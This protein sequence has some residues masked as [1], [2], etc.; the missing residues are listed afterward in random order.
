[1][2]VWFVS[3]LWSS[4]PYSTRSVL[5]FSVTLFSKWGFNIC[6][7]LW[8]DTTYLYSPFQ[9]NANYIVQNAG[10]AY[11]I[12]SWR[13]WYDQ[14]NV[15]S[16]RSNSH[17]WYALSHVALISPP[18]PTFA[19][20]SGGPLQNSNHAHVAVKFSQVRL[21]FDCFGGGNRILFGF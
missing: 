14:F 4:R 5:T 21:C 12:G 18:G 17:P 10:S 9:H 8:P 3:R 7:G 11:V 1:M 13:H 15:P 6:H 19:F 16:H 20:V 2:L